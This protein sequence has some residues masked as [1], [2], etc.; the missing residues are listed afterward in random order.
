MCKYKN[1]Q[2]TFVVISECVCERESIGN[3]R[4]VVVIHNYQQNQKRVSQRYR[5]AINA[6]E[7]AAE[8]E[9]TCIVF[10]GL[11]L[12]IGLLCRIGGVALR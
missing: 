11:L 1:T 9:R 5:C 2:K 10:L 12:S 4:I 6:I 7:R 3:A 8:A